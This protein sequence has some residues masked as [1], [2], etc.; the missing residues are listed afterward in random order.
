MQHFTRITRTRV[1]THTRMRKEF[2][3]SR[4][5]CIITALIYNLRDL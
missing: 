3:P 5:E 2:N 4:F 1:L